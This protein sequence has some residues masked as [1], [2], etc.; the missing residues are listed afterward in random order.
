MDDSEDSSGPSPAEDSGAEP[1]HRE[2]SSGGGDV[3]PEHD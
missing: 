1:E 2:G 3:E